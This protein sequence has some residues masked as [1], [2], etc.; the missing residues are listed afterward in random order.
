M[1]HLIV[2]KWIIIDHGNNITYNNKGLLN[3]NNI[4]NVVPSPSC[5]AYSHPVMLREIVKIN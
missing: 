2:I 1:H 3:L 4:S 5:M